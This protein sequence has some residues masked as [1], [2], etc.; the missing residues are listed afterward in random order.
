[1]ERYRKAAM[2]GLICFF[3]QGT[4]IMLSE[5]PLIPE[6]QRT[7]FIA[8]KFLL[9]VWALPMAYWLNR[10]ISSQT[11]NSLVGI[12]LMLYC[13]H[14]QMFRPL[15]YFG[16]AQLAMAY[17]FLF[18]VS[19]ARFRII[20]GLG[21]IGYLVIFYRNWDV[22][23]AA[24]QHPT[25]SDIVFCVTTVLIISFLANT[26]FASERTFREESLKRFGL[27]GIQSARVLH[28]LK[29]LV[30][31]PT[32]YVQML[33]EKMPVD[34][35]PE[36]MEVLN[37]LARDLDGFKQ[38]ITG[39]NQLSSVR[40][41]ET[42]TFE[43]SEVIEGLRILFRNQLATISIEY[44]NL[45]LRTEQALLSSIFMNIILNSIDAFKQSAVPNPKILISC[46][47]SCVVVKDN[48]GGFSN[49]VLAAVSKGKMITTRE[50]GSGIGLILVF[51]GMKKIGGWAKIY[52]DGAGACV[53]LEFPK[54]VIV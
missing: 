44:S 8:T 1:M 14:G 28:D 27:I 19:K 46:D 18:P 32:L 35:N 36:A 33:K 20:V 10:D 49:E 15:Y 2:W 26:F 53:K 43:L 52:N 25:P 12:F 29:G 38:A 41:E 39:L 30:A 34:A 54:H 17:S 50:K 4:L 5:I 23:V 21:A 11:A 45:T 37:Y 13:M 42:S 3:V 6:S 9:L 40:G 51:D 16:F 22:Y 24:S 7:L 47:G 31:A 48:A